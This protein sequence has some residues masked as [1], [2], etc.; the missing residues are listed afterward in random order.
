MLVD[1]S[2][3]LT[4]SYATSEIVDKSASEGES[5]AEI[6]DLQGGIAIGS[7]SLN[8]DSTRN[9]NSNNT[10]N[11][12]YG[13]HVTPSG[14]DSSD[15]SDSES[16]DFDVNNDN[17]NNNYNNKKNENKNKN[18]NNYNGNNNNNNN[19]NNDKLICES[20]EKTKQNKTKQ[21]MILLEYDRH[22]LLVLDMCKLDV[23]PYKH[24]QQNYR[25]C[26]RCFRQGNQCKI[27][28]IFHYQ[29]PLANNLH[30]KSFEIKNI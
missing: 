12:N 25:I 4:T 11:N 30:D 21:Q 15:S 16:N 8:Y 2:T 18:N 29:Q 5:K 1:E 10:K 20:N 6:Y 19:N 23:Q 7:M 22:H 9:S 24:Q 13:E 17:N 28:R 27:Y 26:N 3:E 14:S